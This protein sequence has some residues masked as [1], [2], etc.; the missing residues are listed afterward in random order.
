[1]CKQIKGIHKKILVRQKYSYCA[2][3][4]RRLARYTYCYWEEEKVQPEGEKETCEIGI[5]LLGERDYWYINIVTEGF[6]RRKD[7]EDMNIAT[8]RRERYSRKV[9]EKLLR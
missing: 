7:W 8:G 4:R 1:M 9:R 2:G 6:G 5:L 3:R